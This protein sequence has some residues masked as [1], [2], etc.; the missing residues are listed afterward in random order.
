MYILYLC[1]CNNPSFWFWYLH[2]SFHIRFYDSWFFFS[3]NL[4]ICNKVLEFFFVL[5]LSVVFL[6]IFYSLFCFVQVL[7]SN[8]GYFT[9]L[10]F[11]HSLNIKMFQNYSC[12]VRSVSVLLWQYVCVVGCVCMCFLLHSLVHWVTY[13]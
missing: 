4:R 1:T 12:M 5:F 10:H 3:L 6:Y 11:T 8:K 7:H 9:A 2:I 13:F